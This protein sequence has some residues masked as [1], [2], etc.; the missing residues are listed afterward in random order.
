MTIGKSA[1]LAVALVSLVVMSGCVSPSLEDAAPENTTGALT[2]PDTSTADGQATDAEI[3]DNSFVQ[4]GATLDETYP[5]FGSIPTTANS[6]ISDEERE[7]MLAEMK[8]LKA[9]MKR[10]GAS[11]SADSK[12]RYRELQDLA[13]KH[14]DETKKQIE[15]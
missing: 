1:V 5:T 14:V 4:E 13:R 2:A 9:S 3:R 8:S 15:Q 11:S 7:A 6:Q 12:A 10:R